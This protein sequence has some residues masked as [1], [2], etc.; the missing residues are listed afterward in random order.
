M[1][2]DFAYEDFEVREAA[3]GTHTLVE[4][5][6][7]AWVVETALTGRAVLH[8]IRRRSGRPTSWSAGDRVLQSLRPPQGP[9]GRSRVEKEGTVHIPVETGVT[10]VQKGTR[11]RLEI[12]SHRL[13][14]RVEELPDETFTRAWLERG[15]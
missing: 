10:N 13:G 15:G 8:E 12:V 2:S 4:D 1:G 7:E 11:T 9:R 5:T 14:D 3:V 6:P